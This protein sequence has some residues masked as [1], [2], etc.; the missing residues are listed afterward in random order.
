MTQD[1]WDIHK[2]DPEYDCFV[3]ALPCVPTIT[4]T[5]STTH[6]VESDETSLSDP[7]HTPQMMPGSIDDMTPTPKAKRHAHHEDDSPRRR[8]KTMTASSADFDKMNVDEDLF[9]GPSMPVPQPTAEDV[10]N[11]KRRRVSD[12]LGETSTIPRNKK[13]T[14]T[15]TCAGANWMIYWL[16]SGRL[17]YVVGSSV[18]AALSANGGRASATD[19]SPTPAKRVRTRSPNAVKRSMEQKRIDRQ[20]KRKADMEKRLK[21]RRKGMNRAFWEGIGLVTFDDDP[22]V[23]PVQSESDDSEACPGDY[24][25]ESILEDEAD[26]ET[27]RL[28]KIEESRRKLAEL[29]KD[30]PLW[31]E[32]AR[33]RQEREAEQEHIRQQARARRRE[34]E[35][36]ECARAARSQRETRSEEEQRREHEA[37]LKEYRLRMFVTQ[38]RSAFRW[39]SQRALERYVRSAAAF[40]A[41]KFSAGNPLT[42][43]S[44]PWPVLRGSF[45]VQDVDW[46]T[47]E[48]FFKETQRLLTPAEFK[49][50]VEK[51]QRRFHPDR[52]RSRRLLLSL[53]NETE[54]D[55]LEVAG[56]TVA[57]VITPLWTQV[58]D[59]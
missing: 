57:Q 4:R 40:D 29:E 32:S 6:I 49:D 52:W 34:E 16:L 44:V 53:E 21:E 13:E 39:N 42:F 24:D 48:A 11:K 58:T 31:E 18:F 28:A 2:L 36:L 27:E 45:S 55:L 1:Q 33:K 8:K 38:P 9:Y 19:L 46:D 30:K 15:R 20:K 10:A 37:R 17:T 22:Q 56:S 26:A 14:P 47:V 7:P 35:R 25:S 43:A 54:R 59:R 3:P 51:S 5:M 12:R 41:A 23:A 50:L